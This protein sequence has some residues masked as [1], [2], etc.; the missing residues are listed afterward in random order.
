MPLVHV[1]SPSATLVWF[2]LY[3][4]IV[5]NARPSNAQS[6]QRASSQ[7]V[8]TVTR[9]LRVQARVLRIGTALL[10][11]SVFKSGASPLRSMHY[12]TRITSTPATPCGRVR[13]WHSALYP[14][15]R[16]LV[17][18]ACSLAAVPLAGG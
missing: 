6:A 11:G 16:L 8:S 7:R 13:R 1:S 18:V 9:S 2:V 3:T 4:W 12:V 14:I 15:A 5:Q 17:A 10:V